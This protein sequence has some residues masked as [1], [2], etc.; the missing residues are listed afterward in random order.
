M[1]MANGWLGSGWLRTLSFA[2]SHEKL[3]IPSL[4]IIAKGNVLLAT[5][6]DVRRHMAGICRYAGPCGRGGGDV[7]GG[8]IPRQPTHRGSGASPIPEAAAWGVRF[9][10]ELDNSPNPSL[11]IV[12]NLLEFNDF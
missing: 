6:L 4:G 1:E 7:G 11:G 10:I 5:V 9:G 2:V 12:Q 8:N 3:E